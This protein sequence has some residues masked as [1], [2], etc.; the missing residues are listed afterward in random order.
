[1]LID[2]LDTLSSRPLLLDTPVWGH[3]MLGDAAMLTPDFLAV[4]ERAAHERRL[5]ASAASVWELARQVECG[6]LLIE[7]LPGLIANQERPPGVTFLPIDT[8]VLL[9]ARLLPPLDHPRDPVTRF[10]AATA[11]RR[12]AVVLTADPTLLAMAAGGTINAYAATA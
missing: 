7:D 9:E 3:V 6:A 10:V 2:D 12:G 11:R 4:I 5:V 8:D 1:M